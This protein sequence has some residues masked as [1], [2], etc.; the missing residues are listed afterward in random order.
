MNLDEH[1]QALYSEAF[2]LAEAVRLF[3]ARR[4]TQRVIDAGL[5]DAD[6]VTPLV[7]SAD[8]MWS[9]RTQRVGAAR[10]GETE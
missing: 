9:I 8:R 6:V 5:L 1:D 4:T 2:R 10:E 7:E 3:L